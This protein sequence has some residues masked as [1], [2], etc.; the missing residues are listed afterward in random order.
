[1]PG[2]QDR[3]PQPAGRSLRSLFNYILPY[4]RRLAVVLLVS[5]VSTGLSLW[6]PYLTKS[7]VDDALIG[8]NL[9]AL[10]RVVLL[11]AAAGAAG[12]VLTLVSGLQYTRVSADILFDMRRELYEHL[13]RLSPRFYASTRLGDIVSRI[14]NDI[15]EIQRIAAEAALAWV[16][17]VLF[18][19]GAVAILIWMDW[20]LFLAGLAT[21]PAAAWALVQYRRRVESRVQDVRERSADIGSFL[22]ETL[23]GVRTVATSN[24]QAREVS[25]FTRLNDAFIAALMRLQRVHYLSGGLPTL[26][27]GAGTAVVFVYGGWRVVQ[28]T[29]TL[30]TLAAFMA[31]QARVVAPVQAL[32][33]LY[34]GLATARVSWMRVAALLETP[35]EVVERPDAPP[36]P[37]VRGLVEFQDVTLTHGR[38]AA[39]LDGVSFRADPGQIVAIVGASGSGKSTIADLLVRLLDPDAGSIRLDGH[40]LRTLRIADVRRHIQAVDQDPV[41][42][43]ASIEENVRYSRPSA[44]DAELA[45]AL[46]AAGIAR[47]V[48]TLPDGLRTIVGD[49]G[50]ALSAG[51][52][53][54]LVLARAFLTSPAILVL[55]EPSAAL[56][57]AVEREVI[58]GYRQLM[59]GRTVILISHRLDVIRTADRAVVLD[60]ARVVEAGPPDAL[61]AGHGV[62]AAL[63]HADRPSVVSS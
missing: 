16:G 46:E 10:Q 11:F 18:L 35:P 57:P 22:I 2:V 61:L 3:R 4:R 43:H 26:L 14:N 53:Q 36:L 51:E 54:R 39:V 1:V 62:F 56:D 58:A 12:F 9:G 45:R 63:F 59:R 44:S 40:D 49:R 25:R 60:G 8:R 28:G 5:L 27:L 32:M 29:M 41:L 24:A 52:R 6:L 37:D 31:Y 34:G 13:Q 55:D 19:A 21:L 7:L 17:N 33:G 30:G 38:G 15:A 23:Q 42:F 20:R 50:L 47:F 48:A